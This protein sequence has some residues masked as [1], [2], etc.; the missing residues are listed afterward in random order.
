[1]KYKNT[2]KFTKTFYGQQFKPG[3]ICEVPG[4]I[5]AIGFIQVSESTDVSSNETKQVDKKQEASSTVS[6][7][8]ETVE[9]KK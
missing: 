9:P 1:M 6:Q 4:Y 2:S 5:N 3:K 8:S 7:K